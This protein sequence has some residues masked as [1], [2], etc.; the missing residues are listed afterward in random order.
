MS[1][2]VKRSEPG[3]Y[4]TDQRQ[5]IWPQAL[6]NNAAAKNK[7]EWT[8]QHSDFPPQMPAYLETS[9]FRLANTVKG[10]LI[11]MYMHICLTDHWRLSSRHSNSPRQL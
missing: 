5:S 2:G 1:E 3:G 10:Y 7:K 8:S 4:W 6:A 9:R 11:Y